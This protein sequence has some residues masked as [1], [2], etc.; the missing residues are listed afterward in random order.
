MAARGQVAARG[1][2][3]APFFEL[4]VAVYEKYGVPCEFS[5]G[6]NM[7]NGVASTTITVHCVP[8][9]A[10]DTKAVKRDI[11]AMVRASVPEATTI[12]VT[13]GAVARPPTKDERQLGAIKAAV[14]KK[15]AVDSASV[16]AAEWN[17][18]I[19]KKTVD[20]ELL[21]VPPGDVKAARS[22]V[23]AIVLSVVPDAT[24]IEITVRAAA[25]GN[26]EGPATRA[27]ATAACL[28]GCIK[29]VSQQRPSDEARTM[30]D[31]TCAC[32][33]DTTFDANGKQRGYK[34][35]F[36]EL[37]AKCARRGQAVL[38][39]NGRSTP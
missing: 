30:C 17:N 7:S 5:T 27:E 13:F 14:K 20:V 25:D 32:L 10:G 8:A 24:H 21:S 15:F 33:I 1:G 28:R 26:S 19:A 16:I 11:E 9:A 39:R 4:S 23:E 38:E 22:A 37:G 36:A 6:T 34:G 2:M 29:R 3:D 35:T 18:G 31:A 12:T